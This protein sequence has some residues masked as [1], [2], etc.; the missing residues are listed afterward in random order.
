MLELDGLV[1]A[2]RDR[3]EALASCVGLIFSVAGRVRVQGAEGFVSGAVVV[4]CLA[5]NASNLLPSLTPADGCRQI[6]GETT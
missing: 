4:R 1:V 2:E 6:S 5:C 3:G